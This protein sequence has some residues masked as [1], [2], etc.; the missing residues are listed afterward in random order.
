MG[1]E[2]ATFAAMFIL[3]FAVGMWHGGALEVH[4]GFG[5]YSLGIHCAGRSGR[6]AV[7]K[8]EGM[9]PGD[10]QYKVVCSLAADSDLF[11]GQ[12]Q[13]CFFQGKQLLR[14][15]CTAT[16]RCLRTSIRKSSGTVPC[17]LWG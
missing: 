16:D 11:T 7:E 13:L 12:R 2:I 15:A 14:T 8:A 10:G 4:H 9:V 3:W 5:S 6:A 1:K 17:C